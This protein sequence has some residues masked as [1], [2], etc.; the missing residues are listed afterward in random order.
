MYRRI[1]SDLGQAAEGWQG[2]WPRMAAQL[3][4]SAILGQGL[5]W[6]FG[7]DQLSIGGKGNRVMQVGFGRRLGRAAYRN[8]PHTRRAL[9]AVK[10]AEV[11]ADLGKCWTEGKTY[12]RYGLA[13]DV[14]AAAVTQ[15]TW[16]LIEAVE[17]LAS[18]AATIGRYRA[19]DEEE[20]IVAISCIYGSFFRY[21]QA[22]VILALG[23]YIDQYLTVPLERSIRRHPV[24][25]PS[26]ALAA[27]A[28]ITW[29]VTRSYQKSRY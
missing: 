7:Y 1:R 22:A 21:G 29:R 12:D 8:L 17:K 11:L 19:V 13:P 10:A 26:A 20:F 2:D 27:A 6:K 5:F 25:V 24:L 14:V 9:Y 3:I 28:A 23:D 16:S 15:P 18:M 4:V